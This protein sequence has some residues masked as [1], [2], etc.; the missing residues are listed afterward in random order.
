M[1]D[2]FNN[3]EEI[4]KTWFKNNVKVKLGDVYCQKWSN[5]VFNNSVCVNYRVMT[6]VKKL[7]D[8][9]IQLPKQYIYP[10]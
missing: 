9:I 6:K 1:S 3:I 7:Q 8:Y 4:N 2:T 5:S 10:F